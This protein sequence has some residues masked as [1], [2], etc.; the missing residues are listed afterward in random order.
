MPGKKQSA[1]KR[2]SI[3][4][5]I[6]ILIGAAYY[7][8]KIQQNEIQQNHRYL[9][10]LNEAAKSLQQSINLLST[11]V[12]Q[13]FIEVQAGETSK[14]DNKQIDTNFDLDINKFKNLLNA[15]QN[16]KHLN[17]LKNSNKSPETDSTEFT[18][19][20]DP[21]EQAIRIDIEE[22]KIT[23]P[24]L[25]LIPSHLSP[26]PLLIVSDKDG[27]ILAEKRHADLAKN[28]SDLRFSAVKSYL[29]STDN[30]AKDEKTETSVSDSI[31]RELAGLHLRIYRQPMKLTNLS[32]TDEKSQSTQDIY[33]LAFVEK[34]DV[35][36]NNLKIGNTAA[37]WAVLSLV[38][39]VAILPILKIQYCA[40][41]YSYSRS[42]VSQFILGLFILFGVLAIAISDQLFYRYW[43][44]Q[45]NIQSESLH[46]KIRHD[47]SYELNKLIELDYNYFKNIQ[48]GGN[49]Q[50]NE[51]S[52]PTPTAEV[53]KS[54]LRNCTLLTEGGVSL[55]DN[56]NA[57]F[58]ENWFLLNKNGYFSGFDDQ[59]NPT[60][61]QPHKALYNTKLVDLKG[62]EYFQRGWHGPLWN[63]EGETKDKDKPFFIQRIRNIHD[64]R[65]NSQLVFKH[66][67][68]SK[69][70]SKNTEYLS[71][72][73]TSLTSLNQ[74]ILPNNFGFAVI[75][76]QGQVLYHSNEE[77]SL[78]ENFFAEN[79]H[80]LQL[81][82]T[83][84]HLT[85]L[86]VDKPTNL[87]LE[88]RHA[89]HNVT[90]GKLHKDIPEWGLVV[91]YNQEEASQVNM[92][93][94]F[95]AVILYL[96]LLIPLVLLSRYLSL[97]GLW[98]RILHY[99]HDDNRPLAF[100]IRYKWLALWIWSACIMQLLS[101]GVL[102][103]V[104]P[105]L[106]F[107]FFTLSLILVVL[108]YRLVPIA[109]HEK[110]LAFKALVKRFLPQPSILFR[111]PFFIP[112]A[113]GLFVCFVMCFL[114]ANNNSSTQVNSTEWLNL[115]AGVTFFILASLLL[116]KKTKESQ[117]KLFFSSNK[118]TSLA[119]LNRRVSMG[120][121]WYLAANIY[122]IT[123]VPAVI[124]INSVNG[125][126][127]AGQATF[128]NQYLQEQ[129]QKVA[130]QAKH[131]RKLLKQNNNDMLGLPPVSPVIEHANLFPGVNPPDTKHIE[132]WL[133]IVDRESN[134]IYS[135]NDPFLK[136][137]IKNLKL[138]THVA[139]E[140]QFEA[141][142]NIQ[143]SNKK[144]LQYDP[145]RFMQAASK[146]FWAQILIITVVVIMGVYYAGLFLVSRKLL[147]EHIFDS[148][149]LRPPSESEHSEYI[150]Q[151]LQELKISGQ[152]RLQFISQLSQLDLES[153]FRAHKIPIH[154]G[155]ISYI[156]DWTDADGQV[157][158]P[159]IDTIQ[160]QEHT[161]LIV[162]QGLAQNLFKRKSRT[163]ALA[164]LKRLQQQK[165]DLIIV[166][167]VSPMLLLSQAENFPAHDVKEAPDKRELW[168]WSQLLRDYDMHY[169]WVARKKSTLTTSPD[170]TSMLI[171]ESTHWPELKQI[172]EIFITYHRAIKLQQQ[173]EQLKQPISDDDLQLNDYWSPQQIVE[174][175]V[176]H[177][178][179][180][181]RLRWEQCCTDE[182]LTLLQLAH[183][184]KLNPA[185]VEAIGHLQRRGLIYRDSGW[186]LVNE[187]FRQF[188]LTAEPLS[189]VEEWVDKTRTSLWH[190]LRAPLFMLV[191]ILFILVI[192]SAN[193]A[194]DSV[195]S[196]LAAVLGVV[197][198]LIQNI[199]SLR[200]VEILP[201]E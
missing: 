84:Q 5:L 110:R 14:S 76:Q 153:A 8:L 31:D 172:K 20:L 43:L 21:N 22:F 42:D 55:A 108:Q 29:A 167:E 2:Y 154:D 124:L 48:Q 4:L 142:N 131:Y 146:A 6:I 7:F 39:L 113:C 123:M 121:L 126:M 102:N 192:F 53:V 34:Q 194:F 165:I 52:I 10:Q 25:D 138:K 115:G 27:N 82:T 130:Q 177:A 109:L 105:R 47:F 51:S 174:F 152:M 61:Y 13:E 181:Y 63:W 144:L 104:L 149:R 179:P 70:N 99:Q 86:N 188:I 117:N 103:N 198:L 62:R 69:V 33:L 89:P 168:Q 87:E 185:N 112:F 98:A 193:I 91:F 155:N 164:V 191:A 60:I 35:V 32:L 78:V 107:F 90:L 137:I 169:Y 171:H 45:K 150:W 57:Y 128:Q 95:L 118:N 73:G 163:Q 119:L 197:P 178:R 3:L 1:F 15:T 175:F 122:L 16:F 156:E 30:L 180:A 28:L 11:S 64:A 40:P 106:A 148:Y 176:H 56:D 129:Q 136:T 77:R 26:F 125:Y 85:D 50:C 166:S 59:Q 186:H 147:G 200:S 111:T 120:Y 24:I 17:V 201:K 157:D 68:D 94:V 96:L 44:Q 88:Y 83:M 199:S 92:L 37:L 67:F 38:L 196:T 41:T 139:A 97:Q 58:I 72:I 145:N 161:P 75:D 80:N 173:A 143:S 101:M 66:Q 93:L 36:L 19:Q 100:R 116:W 182:R 184:A 71:S 74:R 162:L 65:F 127:L 132:S 159:K 158:L 133:S 183:G 49:A 141:A 54:Q 187:S 160:G 23:T 135:D 151:R 79:A 134:N 195:L 189:Q 9:R 190:N 81:L 170:A 46:N 114:P 18:L 140:Y 12:R